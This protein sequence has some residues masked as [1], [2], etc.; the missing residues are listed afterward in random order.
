MSMRADISFV[1]APPSLVLMAIMRQMS[2]R[3]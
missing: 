1:Q 3:C 2:Q